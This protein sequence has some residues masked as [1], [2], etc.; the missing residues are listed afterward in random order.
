[1]DLG[2]VDVHILPHKKTVA[3]FRINEQEETGLA[4]PGLENIGFKNRSQTD[5]VVYREPATHNDLDMKIQQLKKE[6]LELS[7]RWR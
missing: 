7:S 1:M 6:N 5:R 2:K 4:L 3:L